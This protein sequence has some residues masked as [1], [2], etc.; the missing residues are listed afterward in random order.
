M[1]FSNQPLRPNSAIRA[2][3]TMKAPTASAI[4]KPPVTPAAAKTAA[5]G[6]DQATMT[7]LRKMSDGTAQH[8]PIPQPSAHIQELICAGV[9]PKA[10]AA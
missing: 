8:K 5:P 9:A 10:C 4:E 2:A 1:S 3:L 6:V 7:G